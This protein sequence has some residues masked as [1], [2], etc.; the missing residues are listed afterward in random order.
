MHAY[1]HAHI[2]KYIHTWIVPIFIHTHARTQIMR[3]CIHL[4]GSLAHTQV[5]SMK[6]LDQ[7][8]LSEGAG[9]THSL[10]QLIDVERRRFKQTLAEERLRCLH[11][12]P[13]PPTLACVPALCSSATYTCLRLSTSS[14]VISSACG[15]PFTQMLERV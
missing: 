15:K 3:R 8:A 7:P 10:E 9:Q 2:H 11:C 5:Q 4:K 6:Q 14:Q 12:V 13:V 1:T